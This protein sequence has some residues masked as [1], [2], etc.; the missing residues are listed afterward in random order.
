MREVIS[1]SCP[2][3]VLGTVDHGPVRI[4]RGEEVRSGDG[5][6]GLHHQVDAD[7][8]GE[9]QEKSTNINI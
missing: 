9:T 2:P 3:F 1:V 8:P 4:T 5:R 7:I 6:E